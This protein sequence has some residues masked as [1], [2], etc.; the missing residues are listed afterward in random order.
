MDVQTQNN[1]VR[2]QLLHLQH[3]A[4]PELAEKWQ[5][6]FH[7]EPPKYGEIFMRRRLAHRIQELAYG[8]LSDTAR[9]KLDSVN[10]KVRRAHSGLRLGTVI[11]R[12]WRGTKYEVRVCKEGFE[13]N[14]QIYG[15]L[16]AAARAITGVNRNGYEFFG[17]KEK[18]KHD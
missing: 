15:S 1:E 17:I 5:L 8:C 14:G 3:L 12:T 18:R 11:V 13:W 6:L 2:A 9:K 10:G 16:S 7:R 4:M